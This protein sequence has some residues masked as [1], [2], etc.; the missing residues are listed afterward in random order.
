[1]LLQASQI[2]GLPVGA[3]NTQER[4][5]TISNLVIDPDSG[6]LLGF[7]VKAGFF[8]GEKVLSFHDV[9]GVDHTAVLVREREVIL[10]PKE[11]APVKRAIEDKRPLL[12]QKVI[13]E[14]G[15]RLGRVVDLVVN[16]ETA[17]ITKIYVSHLLEER[18]IPLDKVIKVTKERIVV[19]DDVVLGR[20]MV[21][22]TIPV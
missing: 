15:T 4:A 7:V 10:P 8:S 11:I 17:M 19:K 13:T 21:G 1:M 12:G 20:G 22:E 2:I 16:T 18:I 5:G 6:Q 9:T 14:S 3:T